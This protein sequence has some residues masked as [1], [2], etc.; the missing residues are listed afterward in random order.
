MLRSLAAASGQYEV[1]KHADLE[2]AVMSVAAVSFLANL[3]TNQ[4]TVM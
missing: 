3:K 1:K 2:Q 4:T